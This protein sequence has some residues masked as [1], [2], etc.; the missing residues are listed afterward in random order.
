MICS[1]PVSDPPFLFPRIEMECHQSLCSVPAVDE[2]KKVLWSF[3]PWK[4]PGPDGLHPGFFQKTWDIVAPSVV[5]VI[6]EAFSV[7]R[8]PPGL[9]HTYLCLIPKIRNPET[10]G[11]LRPISLCNTILK[12][13]TKI[14]VSRI[15]PLLC[16]LISPLQ[17]SF[18]PRRSSTDNVIIV[19]EI[20]HKFNSM[21]G[22]KGNMLIKLDLEKAYDRLEWGFI[23]QVLHFFN[24][25]PLWINLIMSIISSSSMSILFNGSATDTFSPSR[26]IRQGDPLSPY[27]FILCVE[28]LSIQITL[29]CDNHT[30]R[31]IRT[32]RSGPFLSHLFFANDLVLFAEA[33]I[34][35]CETISALLQDFCVVSGLKVS[36]S[37]SSV[38]FSKNT[39]VG[40]W[41]E[42][43]TA[44]G[45]PET[46]SV[47]K[48]LGC[49]IHQ[50]RPTKLSFQFIIEKI[51]AKLAGWKSKHLSLAGRVSLIK[52]V[53]ETIPSHIMHCNLLP[54]SVSNKID[55]L[56]KNFL[57]GSSSNHK[58]IHAI[59]WDTV[60]RPKALGG[61]GLRKTRNNNMVAMAKLNWKL[62]KRVDILWVR[63][64]KGRYRSTSA[65]SSKPSTTWRGIKAG[66]NLFKE[67][68]R[69]RLGN[70]SSTS[71]WMDNWTGTGPLRSKILGP[72]QRQE[73][74]LKVKECWSN[75]S[76]NLQA[77]SFV[78]PEE[79]LSSI[80]VVPFQWF[81][82]SPD[83]TIWN[84]STNG[85]FNCKSA[86]SLIPS[87]NVSSR[88]S[89]DWI[90]HLPCSY[91]IQHFVWLAA[92]DRLSTHKN[93]FLRNITTSPFCEWCPDIPESTYHVLCD[94][95]RASN[96]WSALQFSLVDSQALPFDWI[97]VNSKSVNTHNSGVP[98]N[99]IFLFAIWH[100]WL[101][102]NRRLF[103]TNPNSNSSIIDVPTKIS[104]T[105]LNKSLGWFF[106]VFQERNS[107]RK[108]IQ[109][110][111]VPPRM[112]F[113]KLNTDGAYN[114][115]MGSASTGG[116]LRDHYGIWIGGFHRNIIADSSLKAELWALRDG[117]S[118]AKDENIKKLEIEVDSMTVLNLIHATNMVNHPLVN[119][120]FDCRLL[121]QGFEEVSIT[122]IYR[123]A[124]RCADALAN[125]APV[126]VGDLYIYPVIP[127]CISNFLYADLI[128]VSY[129]RIVNS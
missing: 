117:L 121:M 104:I 66:N 83:C 74:S 106:L 19:Q 15:R 3:K 68:T 75:H 36:L 20:V 98:K 73:S 55:Q 44:L 18:L 29:A 115:A 26:G 25:P 59:N 72:L 41:V 37:K 2:I 95:P 88:L 114:C 54:V 129:P 34:A 89:W 27:I 85:E 118:L 126:S 77:I 31:P 125:D 16:D 62:S 110:G 47:G 45:F 42:F 14:L 82:P 32:S 21:K 109:V 70:G 119:L 10:V 7:G 67:G 69:V 86:H 1:K 123:E 80:H 13:V 87:K 122:H 17:S 28:Y 105:I 5:Q 81:N 79:I 97:R 33:S 116:I 124:N 51:E 78:L 111:W 71:F 35:N 24:F 102:R 94:C 9:N 60:T 63:I 53:I 43:A 100:I 76:W 90:W 46:S 4:S 93:L 40:A 52:S 11:H 39:P 64:L 61:L 91:R 50:S 23:R 112:G 38:F 49:P 12:L 128:G 101:D 84:L 22:S 58:K 120:L 92:H 103:Y 96:I 127:S 48:Y 6:E 99:I 57:W 8:I 113:S 108:D 56:S 107:H 30:W 65:R